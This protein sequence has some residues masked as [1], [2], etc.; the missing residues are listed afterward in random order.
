MKKQKN[1][2]KEKEIKILVG[3][4]IGMYVFGIKMYI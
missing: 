4:P 3:M 2:N 1:N